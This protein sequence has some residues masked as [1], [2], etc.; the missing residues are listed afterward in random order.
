MEDLNVYID[1]QLNI[2]E[3]TS[4]F[5]AQAT[6]LRYTED[7]ERAITV[8]HATMYL[9][10]YS[11]DTYLDV[12]VDADCICADLYTALTSLEKIC[13]LDNL[14]GLVATFHSLSMTEEG[15]GL[16]NAFMDKIIEQLA[17]LNVE[18]VLTTHVNELIK[19]LGFD[20][21]E[22][23]DNLSVMYKYLQK[24]YVTLGN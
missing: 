2:E 4:I 1:F 23:S 17:L 22:I 21:K 9:V 19:P 10:K 20:K 15:K 6:C 8:G 5:S 14:Q 24:Q 7:L 11:Q 12:C 18:V 13:D 16:E 3:G